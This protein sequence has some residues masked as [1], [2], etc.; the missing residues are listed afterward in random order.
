MPGTIWSGLAS[1]GR[2][3]LAVSMSTICDRNQLRQQTKGTET[4]SHT[5]EIPQKAEKETL[6]QT[7]GALQP[8]PP[9][10]WVPRCRISAWDLVARHSL[11]AAVLAR[12]REAGRLVRPHVDQLVRERLPNREPTMQ[13]TQAAKMSFS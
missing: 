4:S 9:A 10:G 8:T 5:V 13:H 11:N 7:H 3:G 1:S 12:V 6:L 2:P